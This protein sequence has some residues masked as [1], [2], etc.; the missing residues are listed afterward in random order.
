MTV[1]SKEWCEQAAEAEG[2]SEI[3]AGATRFFWVPEHLSGALYW[4]AVPTQSGKLGEVTEYVTY[5]IHEAKQ[6]PTKAECEA[7]IKAEGGYISVAF[8]AREHG[9]MP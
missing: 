3:T 1:F 5:S 4:A 8:V 7:W 9:V 6:F 2:D